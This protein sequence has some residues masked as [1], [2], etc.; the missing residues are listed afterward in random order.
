MKLNGDGDGTTYNPF[1]ALDVVGHEMTHGITERTS[2]LVYQNESG[3]AN[4]SY[5]DIFGETIDQL[6]G[7]GDDAPD[8]PRT[9]ACSAEIASGLQEGDTI[10]TTLDRPEI[11]AGALVGEQ[12]RDPAAGA[13]K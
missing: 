7:R 4:E 10:V 1:D 3:A 11:K 2:D 8:A 9:D 12:K 13:A 5:S 6:N